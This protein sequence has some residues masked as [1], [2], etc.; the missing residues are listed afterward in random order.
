M[1]IALEGIRLDSWTLSEVAVL[2]SLHV[3]RT[4]DDV[5]T[6]TGEFRLLSWTIVMS[7]TVGYSDMFVVSQVQP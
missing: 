6:T 3:K 1:L 4:P 2:E 7:A 5:T